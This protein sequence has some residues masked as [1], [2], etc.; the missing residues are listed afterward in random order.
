MIN[1]VIKEA[2]NGKQRNAGSYPELKAIIL[3]LE[4]C[5][6]GLSV[7]PDEVV[8]NLLNLNNIKDVLKG[9]LSIKT[10]TAHIRI[11]VDEGKLKGNA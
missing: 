11:W 8:N 1:T 10:L 5:C 4:I 9:D 6:R 3:K 7:T 2:L